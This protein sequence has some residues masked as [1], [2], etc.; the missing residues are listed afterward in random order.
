M[1]KINGKCPG[2]MDLIVEPQTN[3]TATFMGMPLR[4]HDF[5]N[6]SVLVD[7]NGEAHTSYQSIIIGENDNRSNERAP[8]NKLL[9]KCYDKS[10]KLGHCISTQTQVQGKPS[11]C[12]DQLIFEENFNSSQINTDIWSY[13][14]RN[15]LIG[16]QTEEFVIFDDNRE[17][18]YLSEGTL[19]IRP[20]FASANKRTESIDLGSRCTPVFYIIAECKL[21][22]QPPRIYGPPIQSS[23]IHT[24]NNFKFKYGKVEIKA[25]LPKGDWLLPYIMLQNDAPFEKKQIRIAFVRGNDQLLITNGMKDIGG[26]LLYS[27]I[28]RNVDNYTTDFREYRGESHFGNDFHTYSL[29]WTNQSIT[30]AVDGLNYGQ[31][32]D[33]INVFNEEFFISIGVSAGGH[34]EFPDN[35]VDPNEKPWRNTSPKAVGSFWQ[36]IKD[37]TIIWTDDNQEMLID[38]I[39]IFAV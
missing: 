12:K 25:K 31:I 32:T 26:R 10:P 20:T 1:A 24:R 9:Q 39:R 8:L 15:L 36:G 29:T 2:F 27:G 7:H 22:V 38:Y 11:I 18:I 5:V 23:H 16:K 4:P 3:W 19:H 33:N 37:G 6:I 34:I 28:V 35:L 13:D 30:M 17:N 14:R 21:T